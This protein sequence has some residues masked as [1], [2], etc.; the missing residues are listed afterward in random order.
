MHRKLTCQANLT[1]GMISLDEFKKLL[2]KAAAGLS[3]AEIE[4]IRELEYRIADATFDIWLRERN[5]TP[6]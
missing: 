2:G 1:P 6:Q 5:S 3:D 4:S